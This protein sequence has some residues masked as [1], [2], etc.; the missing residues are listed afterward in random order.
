M[1]RYVYM[2]LLSVCFGYAQDTTDPLKAADWEQQSKWVDS[3][4]NQMSLDEKLGQLFMVAAFSE[5]GEAH[6]KAITQQIEDFH[7]GGI[8]FSLG[9]PVTQTQW[10]NAFQQ[11]SR[12]PLLIGMDAEWGV[13][14]RLDSVRPFPWNMTLGALQDNRLVEEIGFR[15][16]E[17]AQRLG[18]HIN[19][20]PDIDINTNPKNPIIGN[21]SFGEDKINVAEKGV[22]YMRGMHR[23]G[24]LSSAK[25][26]P[27]HGDTAKDSHLDLPLI[28]FDKS[29]ILSTELYPFERLIQAGVS[30][31]MVAHL[32][33]PSLDKGIPSSLSKKIVTDL[34][35]DQLGFKGLVIT[36][37][38]NMGGASEVSKIKSIEV[39]A[40]LA[41]NDLL[42]IPNDIKL[43]LRKMKR[44]YR[45]NKISEKRLAHSVKKI[46][47]AKYKLGLNQ[48]QPIARENL[49]TDLNTKKDDY[50]IHKA[51]DEAI[52]LIKNDGVIPLKTTTTYGL[53]SLGDADGSQF[54]QTLGKEIALRRLSFEGDS[55]A[56]LTAAEKLS[57]II[58]GF[59]R[60]NDTPW[61][62][63]DF[64]PEERLLLKGL[65][66]KHR[67][68]LVSFVKPYALNDLP[69]IDEFSGLV[70][71][72]QNNSEAQ[73]LTAQK[74]L[75]HRKFSGQLPVS[76][77]AKFKVGAGNVDHSKGPLQPT[78]PYSVGMDEAK[79]LAIDHLAEIT[80]DSMM[81][82]GFQVLAARYG[83]IFYH[84]AYGYHT[85][86]K[87][88]PVQLSDLYDVASLTK[89]LATLPL[90]IQEVDQ[91]HISFESTLGELS[92]RF[93]GTNKEGLTF[94]E[95]FSHQAGI[96]PWV[97]FYRTTLRSRS[98]KLS[99]KFYRKVSSKRFN[100]RVADHIYGRN[101]LGKTQF[102][103]LLNSVLIE[104]GYHYSDLPFIFAQSFLEDKF[105]KQ[106]SEL[107][108]ERIIAPLKLQS[109]L[110]NPL[111]K[112]DATRIVPSEIDT[113]FRRQELKGYVHDMTAALQGGV[114]GHAGLFSNAKEVATIMQMYLQKGTYDG[115]KFFSSSTFDRFN[116]CYYCPEENR[117]GVGLDKPQLWGG[118]MTFQGISPD[119][120]GH[121]GFTGTFAWA[122]PE[123]KIIFVFLSNRTYPTMDNN[124]LI[125]HNIRTRMLKLIYDSIL[126]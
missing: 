58:V 72:Y 118:G 69:F 111:E 120:F 88:R 63:A 124:K 85:Y 36:D 68:I 99:R 24:V 14:M 33:I 96:I 41:G 73:E 11:Q 110:F 7:L 62:A 28:K 74:L 97:P 29:R 119:S 90:L 70:I 91:R 23:A 53:L 4:Y 78:T 27:G 1:M 79:L 48:L 86:A 93:I 122:D 92:E 31:V 107:V 49:L 2:T 50:L 38:L 13:A 46:L 12:T 59:H 54:A 95:V 82:P 83:K 19:F 26:F 57:T 6:F 81:A 102:D 112:V 37:A 98:G 56:T 75:G 43:A 52:T 17:Q 121:A 71:G 94:K 89:I 101:N 80:L 113:Y 108:N 64:S 51:M 117:R 35:L 60:S 40:F 47:K 34:L 66:A 45:Q 39:A 67:V 77:N 65:L 87:K 10:L 106:F 25:H 9:D 123:T 5:N 105:S 126:F 116:Q 109:T 16:G 42:I 100:V 114:S 22:A 3:I 61:K 18:I 103:A 115:V 20:A 15:I 21:R 32:N 125:D 55:A 30:S 104:K 76:I 44:A 8:I 84:K